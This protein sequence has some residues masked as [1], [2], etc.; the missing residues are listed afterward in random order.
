MGRKVEGEEY[1]SVV[2]V[3]VVAV[4]AVVVVVGKVEAWLS[5]KPPEDNERLRGIEYIYTSRGFV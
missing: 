5:L 2:F 1:E 4:V 3:A